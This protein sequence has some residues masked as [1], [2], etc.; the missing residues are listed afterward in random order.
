MKTR[1]TVDELLSLAGPVAMDE[2][3]EL[4]GELGVSDLSYG[5][6]IAL[7]PI[8]RAAV[9]RKR[10]SVMAPAKLKLCVQAQPPRRGRS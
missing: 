3:V 1:P 6:C 10:A 7:L 9:E 4:L 2:V 5:E 8:L